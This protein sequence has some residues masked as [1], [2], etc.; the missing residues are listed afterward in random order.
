MDERSKKRRLRK[1]PSVSRAKSRPEKRQAT[2]TLVPQYG[3]ANTTSDCNE[4]AVRSDFCGQGIQHSGP[5]NFVVQ[6]NVNIGRVNYN[7]MAVLVANERN[8]S[9]KRSSE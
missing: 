5:G 8:R 1:Q 6:G 9:A 3:S 7:W 4:V 2:P